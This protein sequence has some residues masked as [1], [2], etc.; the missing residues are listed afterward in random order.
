MTSQF[1][2]GMVK[3]DGNQI[4]GKVHK[5]YLF[6]DGYQN[7]QLCKASDKKLLIY[8]LLLL[9]LDHQAHM[10]LRLSHLLAI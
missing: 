9:S 10:T 8:M 2:I 5:I 1:T 4:K 7:N 3:K 6:T